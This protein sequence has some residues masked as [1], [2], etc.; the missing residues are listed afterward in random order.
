MLETGNYYPWADTMAASKA[1]EEGLKRVRDP[2]IG[3]QFQ[4]R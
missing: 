4:R 3:V 2:R 1:A